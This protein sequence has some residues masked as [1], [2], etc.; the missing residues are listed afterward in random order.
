MSTPSAPPVA[1]GDILAVTIDTAGPRG[2]GIVHLDNFILFVE[3]IA[4]GTKAKVK[5]THL[6]RT[7][8]NA[9]RVG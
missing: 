3:N 4:T 7:Y 9:K 1:V 2:Q 5:I 6:G 8:A